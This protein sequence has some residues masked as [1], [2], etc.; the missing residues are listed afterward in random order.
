MKRSR[1]IAHVWAAGL[2]LAAATIVALPGC[3]KLPFGEQKVG[4][5]CDWRTSSG[6]TKDRCFD[7]PESDVASAKKGCD[8]G[9]TWSEKAC[10][11][12]GAVLGCKMDSGVTK[13]VF[14]DGGKPIKEL[15]ALECTAG[16]LLGADGK[17]TE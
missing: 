7:Y 3:D 13:W 12:G 10:D 9:R 4:G 17:P 16:K 15:K 11:H 8:E 14:Q 6:A 1:R 5:S 2:V